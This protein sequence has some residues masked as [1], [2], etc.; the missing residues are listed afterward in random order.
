M[1]RPPLPPFTEA[2]AIEKIRL[3]EDGWNSRDPARVAALVDAVVSSAATEAD[4]LARQDAALER[5]VARDF[6][7]LV[8]GFTRRVLDGPRRPAPAVAADFWRQ[9]RLAE[10]LDEIR[11]TRPA[12]FRAL[13]YAPAD[14]APLVATATPADK[15]AGRSP[16]RPSVNAS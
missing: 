7:G 15:F 12:A 1:S 4:V 6:A 11:Q 8:V 9:F 5:L 16:T 10:E 2:T 3:A 13:P 14:A